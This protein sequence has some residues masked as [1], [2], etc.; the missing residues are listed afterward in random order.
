MSTDQP[1]DS[2]GR[3]LSRGAEIALAL[4]KHRGYSAG[5]ISQF[6]MRRIGNLSPNDLD[7]LNQISDRALQS[8]NAISSLPDGSDIPLSMIPVVQELFGDQP[9]GRRVFY[10]TEISVAGEDTWYRV[11]VSSPTAMTVD[12]LRQAA[13]E[14]A[15]RINRDYPKA[16]G[17]RFQNEELDV[18]VRITASVRRF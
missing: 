7:T 14:E 4:A 13:M 5:E 16:F 11:D 6:V 18:D 10:S 12:E 2:L 17:G 9:N 1:Y 3:V 15:M 8:G